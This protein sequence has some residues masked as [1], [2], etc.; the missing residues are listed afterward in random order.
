MIWEFI[1]NQILGMKWLN[2]LIGNALTTMGLDIN[3]RVGGSI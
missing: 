1:Q 2:E 3:T